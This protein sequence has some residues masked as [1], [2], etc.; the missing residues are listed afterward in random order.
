[1]VKITVKVDGMACNMCESHVNDAVRNNFSVK[2]VKSDHVKGITEIVA[3]NDLDS[4]KLKEVI[5]ATGYTVG[6][7]TS[8]PYKKKGLFHW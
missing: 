6:D 4:A 3:E 1:M 5:G 2:S 8:E 7:V